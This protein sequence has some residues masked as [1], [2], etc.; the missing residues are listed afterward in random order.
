MAVYIRIIGIRKLDSIEN[1]QMRLTQILDSIKL[2]LKF[3]NE[4]SINAKWNLNITEYKKYFELKLFEHS[5]QIHFDNKNFIE[6]LG[7]EGWDIRDFGSDKQNIDYLN[8]IK[9]IFRLIAESYGIKELIYFSECFFDPDGIREGE[10]TFED[11]LELI[12]L[13]PNS[14]RTELYEL[15]TS[16]Y[17]IE[18][19]NPVANICQHL[20]IK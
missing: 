4:K 3:I 10:S 16:E 1:E 20:R 6:F 5:L 11:F 7:S 19:I 13:N 18:S 15:K 12:K 14:M 17:Y 2:N 8:G 9:D